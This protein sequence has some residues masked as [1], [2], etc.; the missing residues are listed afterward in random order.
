MLR[1]IGPG[2]TGRVPLTHGGDS[3]RTKQIGF[4]LEH[5]KPYAKEALFVVGDFNT[6]ALGFNTLATSLEPQY[7]RLLKFGLTDASPPRKTGAGWSDP[8]VTR[9]PWPR[10]RQDVIGWDPDHIFFRSGPTLTVTKKTFRLHFTGTDKPLSDHNLLA[11]S[12]ALEP[13]SAATAAPSA[14]PTGRDR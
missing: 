3:P 7:E 8:P 11:A 12:F 14:P 5:I 4:L 13:T 6:G 1:K 2:F 9:P 10:T